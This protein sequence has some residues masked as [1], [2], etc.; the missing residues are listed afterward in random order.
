MTVIQG[1]KQLYAYPF[2]MFFLSTALWAVVAV[3]VW[4]LQIVGETSFSLAYPPLSWHRHEMLFGIV[5]AAIAGFLLT[6]VSVWT[7]TNRTH[8]MRL[9]LLWLVWAAGRILSVTGGETSELLCTIINLIFMPLVILDAG[10]R[11]FISKQWRHLVV[12][13]VLLM[14]W[15]M[16]TGLLIYGYTAFRDGGLIMVA[17]LMLLIGGRITPAFSANWLRNVGIKENRITSNAMLEISL[18]VTL[19]VLLVAILSGFSPVVAIAASVATLLSLIRVMLWRPWL[20]GAEPL[21]WILHLS[22]FWIP[23]SFALLA[24]SY[25]FNWPPVAWQHALG[26]GGVG[27]L[28]LGVMTRVSLGHTGLALQLPV[29]MVAAYLFIQASSLIR[30]FT[31]FEIISWR[32]GICLA[33]ATWILAFLMFIFRYLSILCSPRADGLE[34]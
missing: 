30:I 16:Q 4:I 22:L 29:G 15:L 1:F 2:R 25:L 20:V 12:V 18:M 9:G 31:A 17:M 11:I 24:G 21:L 3:V 5:N 13:F 6:A 14:I 7:K 8:G 26:I 19:V 34:G 10:G 23:V 32:W 27:G 28:I 33:A